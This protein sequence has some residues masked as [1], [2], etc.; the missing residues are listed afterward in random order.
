[1]KTLTTGEAA[2]LC[3]VNFRTVIRWIE[4]GLLVAHRL[5]G[6]GDHRIQV[7]DFVQFLE[8]NNIPVPEPLLETQ[9]KT[10][11]AIDDESDVTRAYYRTLKRAGLEV[12]AAN[13]G[14]NAG[15]KL[16]SLK[17]ALVI[18]DLKMPNVDGFQVL[19]FIRTEPSLKGIKVLVA[20]G[21]NDELLA[22][23]LSAGANAVLAKPFSNQVLL[24]EVARLLRIKLVIPESVG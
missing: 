22:K 14:F 16:L 15:V 10:V 19:Q 1:M 23:A 7:A 2:A 24:D 21:L 12:V 17:P 8:Q 20:S 5:P 11:L 6:R 3:G 9:P 13:D 4:K 18:L